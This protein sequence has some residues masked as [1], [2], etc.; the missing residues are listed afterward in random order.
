M[1]K[2]LGEY[3]LGSDAQSAELGILTDGLPFSPIF[4]SSPR[5]VSFCSNR[6]C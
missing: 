5:F 4:F 2:N 6:R 1:R 3:S